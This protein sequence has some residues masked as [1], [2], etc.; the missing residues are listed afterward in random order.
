MKKRRILVDTDILIDFLRGNGEA[1]QYIKEN[2]SSI[3]LS[4][5]TVAE[6]YSGVRDG[7]EKRLLDSFIDLVEIIPVATDV[8]IKAGLL[9]RDFHKSHGTGLA[10]ALIAATA[11]MHAD[12]FKTC[13][14][15][16][17]PMI[18]GITPPYTK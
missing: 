13:N 10:D 7:R 3:I 17:F 12:E 6:L 1:T 11:E 8:A 14:I 15:K 18:K 9:K 5:V 4:S 16:H 2:I